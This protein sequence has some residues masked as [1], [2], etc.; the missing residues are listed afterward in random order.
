MNLIQNLKMNLIWILK[1]WDIIALMDS[2]VYK[3][4]NDILFVIFWSMKQKL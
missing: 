2:L 1:L 4:S 3:L